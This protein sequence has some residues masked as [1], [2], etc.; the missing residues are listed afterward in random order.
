MA[1]AAIRLLRRADSSR[2]ETRSDDQGRFSFAAIDGGEYRITAEAGGFPAITK[3]VLVSEEG[4]QTERP[5]VSEVASQRVWRA[6]FGD[7]G[8]AR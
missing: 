4:A 6:D 5:Q 2:R 3:T 7:A 8:S 1:G